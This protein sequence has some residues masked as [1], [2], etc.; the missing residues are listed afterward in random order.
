MSALLWCEKCQRYHAFGDHKVYSMDDLPNVVHSFEFGV[1][2]AVLLIPEETND[3]P[4]K[5]R[6]ALG[7]IPANDADIGE[8]AGSTPFDIPDGLDDLGY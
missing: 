5:Q 2:L 1:D 6:D 4:I 8:N 3:L 7:N